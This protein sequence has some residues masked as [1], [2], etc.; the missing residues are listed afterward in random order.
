MC[1]FA[2]VKKVSISAVIHD[3]MIVHSEKIV[4]KACMFFMQ[5]FL[6]AR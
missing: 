3:K 5:A 2:I 6:T 4:K 1:Y